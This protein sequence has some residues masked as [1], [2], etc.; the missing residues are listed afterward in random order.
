M[1]KNPD[2][3]E[4]SVNCNILHKLAQKVLDECQGDKKKAEKLIR[5]NPGLSQ[6]EI[7]EAVW[8]MQYFD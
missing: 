5:S 7:D 1:K 3:V 6:D 8:A 4:S 2:L